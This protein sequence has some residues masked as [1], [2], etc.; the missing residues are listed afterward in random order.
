PTFLPSRELQVI[1]KQ[2][3]IQLFEMEPNSEVVVYGISMKYAHINPISMLRLLAE[4]MIPS[5]CLSYLIFVLCAWK[6]RQKLR[7]Y[8]SVTLSTKTEAMQR[9]FFVTLVFQNV[10]P[11]AV[12]SL[13][14]S[15][16]STAMI[17]GME[18]DQLAV[19]LAFFYFVLPIVQ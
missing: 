9:R 8:G 11:L 17:G 19:I 6:I 7:T 4:A 18:L 14:L 13:P 2:S 3:L 15:L 5:Y 16:L 10:L 12:M 1:M